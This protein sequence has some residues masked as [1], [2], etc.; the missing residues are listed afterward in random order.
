[1]RDEASVTAVGG[2]ALEVGTTAGVAVASGEE[3]GS[4]AS[5]RG[6]TVDGTVVFTDSDHRGPSPGPGEDQE[7]TSES[8]PDVLGPVLERWATPAGEII[9]VRL[10][11]RPRS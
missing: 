3:D 11:R 6:E 9:E 1:M 4:I 10:R 7:A 2:G 5:L 8:A